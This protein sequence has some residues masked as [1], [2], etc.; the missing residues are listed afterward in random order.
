[1]SYSVRIQWYAVANGNAHV[2][3]FLPVHDVNGRMYGDT[4]SGRAY[5]LD[6]AMARAEARARDEASQFVGDWDVTVECLES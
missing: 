6:E 4:W 1:M 5:D 3:G 2:G